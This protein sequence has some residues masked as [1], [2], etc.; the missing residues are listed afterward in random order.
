MAKE[1]YIATSTS[2]AVKL[3]KEKGAYLAGGTEVNRLGSSVKASKLVSIGRLGL[4]EIKKSGSFVKI[5]ATSTFQE[6]IDNELVPKYLKDAC[7]FMYSRT[8]RNM[9]TIGGNVALLRD[10]SYLCPV[11]LA[12]GAKI[13]F[14][15]GKEIL[16]EDYLN[17][18]EKYEGKLITAIYVKSKAK[19]ASK[20]YANTQESHAMLTMS[21]CCV[22]RNQYVVFAAIKNTGIVKLSDEKVIY[23]LKSDMFGSSDYKKYII[24]LTVKDLCEKSKEVA[25]EN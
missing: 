2:E 13:E 21:A 5:G 18:K 10:D 4:D 7:H 14:S 6:I 24:E 12:T 16:L 11:L 20:R 1:L 3:V 17:H 9:A 23:K 22:K 19:V 15:T 8:K 25:D